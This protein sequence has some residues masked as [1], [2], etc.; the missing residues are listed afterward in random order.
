MHPDKN[1]NDEKASEN[2][3]NLNKA[4]TILMDDEKRRI[5]DQTGTT[6][7][8]ALF[9]VENTYN[10]FK[11]IF[12]TITEKDIDDFTLRYRGSEMEV[13]D[14]I[15]FYNENKGDMTELL[16]WIPLSTNGDRD[17]FIAIYQKLIAEKKI[18]KFKS[19]AAT[20]SKIRLLEEDDQDEVEESKKKYQDLCQQ[21]IKRNANS[22]KYFE[23][24]SK[25]KLIK[26]INIVRKRSIMT[27]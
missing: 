1:P 18:K 26:K 25:M 7:E 16:E 15:N 6:D 14:L 10:Y 22:G 2:F 8:D 11:D 23:N 5:Y 21:I 9:D 3:A 24:L 4:Y 20:K 13:E 27:I 19:F 12:P 17:R